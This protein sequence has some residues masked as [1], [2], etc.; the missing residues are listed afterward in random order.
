[1]EKQFRMLKLIID[2]HTEAR[3]A[4]EAGVDVDQV[5]GLPVLDEIARTK[6]IPE[7]ELTRFDTIAEHVTEQLSALASAS[8]GTRQRRGDSTEV[9]GTKAD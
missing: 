9:D 1:M 2:F 7:E 6:Y 5:G 4:L 8:A 3:Q